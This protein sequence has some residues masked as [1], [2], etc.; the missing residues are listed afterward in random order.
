MN[1]D[2]IKIIGLFIL[3][4]IVIW[5]FIAFY[6]FAFIN[7][8]IIIS[9]V[10]WNNREVKGV[11]DAGTQREGILWDSSSGNRSKQLG[12]FLFETLY[13]ENE[14][15]FTIIKEGKILQQKTVNFSNKTIK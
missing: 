11:M 3:F 6:R 12:E 1:K 8:R 9:A 10:D 2:L 14:V 13:R 5:A 15:T 4:L 7:S